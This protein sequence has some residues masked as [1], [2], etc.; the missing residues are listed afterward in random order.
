MDLLGFV[1]RKRGKGIIIAF[2]VIRMLLGQKIRQ[3]LFMDLPT[4]EQV[5]EQKS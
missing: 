2:G 1:F 4:N 3:I 5:R